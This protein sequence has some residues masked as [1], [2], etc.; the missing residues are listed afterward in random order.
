MIFKLFA[1]FG[2]KK[3]TTPIQWKHVVIVE[4][5]W[6]FAVSHQVS[7]PVDN[8]VQSSYVNV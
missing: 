2:L 4:G 5:Y 8:I 7:V 1:T 6:F 3:W